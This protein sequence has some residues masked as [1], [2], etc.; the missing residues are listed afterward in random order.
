MCFLSETFLVMSFKT[1]LKTYGHFGHGLLINTLKA[2]GVFVSERNVSCIR[3]SLCWGAACWPTG[4]T[5]GLWAA[6]LPGSAAV[7]ARFSSGGCVHSGINVLSNITCFACK[8][9]F[10]FIVLTH[11]VFVSTEP[12]TQKLCR[13][14]WWVKCFSSRCSLGPSCA[15][16]VG[17]RYHLDLLFGYLLENLPFLA[18][19]I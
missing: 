11:C 7:L 4:S 6:V 14:C 16:G 18:G 12:S 15:V 8:V 2:V 17:V 3:L 9:V 1:L 13:C 5:P 10:F 19:L